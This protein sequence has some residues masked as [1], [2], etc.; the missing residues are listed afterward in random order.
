MSKLSIEI[1]V[2]NACSFRCHYCFESE[3]KDGCNFVSDNSNELIQR[4]RKLM[5]SAKINEIADEFYLNFW[6]GEPTL[7]YDLIY[8]IVDEFADDENV[9]F[10]VYTN[11]SRI[12]Q[13]LPSLMRGGSK[14]SVQ[15]SYDGCP[16][17]D[18]RRRSV[19]D[20]PTSQIVLGGMDLLQQYNIPFTLKGTIIYEDFKY[21]DQAWDDFYNLRQRYGDNIF[22]SLTV[23]YHNV[24]FEDFKSTIE[25]GLIRVAKKE[26]KF[27]LENGYFLSNIFSDKKRTCNTANMFAIDTDG[28]MYPCHG[29]I[30]SD[31]NLTFGNLFDNDYIDKIVNNHDRFIYERTENEECSNCIALAC[32]RCNVKKFELSE[33]TDFIER[34]T[35]FTSQKSLCDYFKLCGKIGRGLHLAL[36]DS[37]Q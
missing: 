27:Y 3:F 29:G 30:Y 23:D 17:H 2:T 35:D 37:Q 31:D 36:Q 34:W 25:Q 10:F 9:T 33:K 18:K 6:G 5:R 19:N 24:Y 7:N 21:I 1:T 22:Y 32:T 26:Y 28:N 16:I 4:L 15:V 12:R 13:M 8:K 14:F 11:G 20:K